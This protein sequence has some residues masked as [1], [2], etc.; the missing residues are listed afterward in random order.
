MLSTNAHFNRTY[1]IYKGIGPDAIL[2][3]KVT[4]NLFN[5]C[6]NWTRALLLGLTVH[7]ID[8]KPKAKTIN[9]RKGRLY[10]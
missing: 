6:F 7:M 2:I 8:Q 9:Y 1:G 5:D 3:G 4:T 10:R